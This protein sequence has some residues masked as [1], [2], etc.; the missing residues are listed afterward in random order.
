MFHLSEL[1]DKKSGFLVDGEVEIVAQITVL[2]T[3]RRF[4]VSKD[5]N[6]EMQC[7][8]GMAT[9]LVENKELNDDDKAGLV[10]VKGFQV[11]PSQVRN[12]E[13]LQTWHSSS[14]DYLWLKL[15]TSKYR[16]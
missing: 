10:N 1:T 16:K 14:R 8:D 12:K 3:D 4:H 7:W 11:L 2:E 5:Y 6:M 13:N 15:N 9:T